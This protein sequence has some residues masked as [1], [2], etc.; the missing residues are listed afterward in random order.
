[1]DGFLW[2]MLRGV[3]KTFPGGLD[4]G[5][6]GLLYCGKT[7]LPFPSL[8]TPGSQ[9]SRW[10]RLCFSGTERLCKDP[11]FNKF[12]VCADIIKSPTLCSDTYDGFVV[13]VT[14]WGLK[15]R[16]FYNIGT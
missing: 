3:G 7:S 14:R 11:Y 16:T 2:W 12:S 5:L 8:V 9:F 1:M 13:D 6:G 10:F 4:C 15:R